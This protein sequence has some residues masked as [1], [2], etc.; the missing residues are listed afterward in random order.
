MICG[1]II[2]L[3]DEVVEEIKVKG[4]LYIREIMNVFGW[5]MLE[6]CFKCWLVLNYYLGM[7]NLIKYEDDWIF[8]FVN[9]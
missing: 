3:R 1:C 9:E 7:I 4:L 6:G 5:K 2:L 8:C